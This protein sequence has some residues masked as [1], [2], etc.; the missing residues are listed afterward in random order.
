MLD[1]AGFP[2]GVVSV[3]PAERETSE[4]LAVHPGVDKVSFTGST[5]AGRHLAERCG[6][7][8]RPITLEL[9]G[10]SAALILDD[11]DIQSTV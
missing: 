5:V 11:A 1:E 7:L 8:L 2:K 10:K 9:G 4:Y 3:L 6:A